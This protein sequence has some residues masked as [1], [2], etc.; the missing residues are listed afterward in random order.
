MCDKLEIIEMQLKMNEKFKVNLIKAIEENEYK[1]DIFNRKLLQ[2]LKQLANENY[3]L[4]EKLLSIE[5][6]LERLKS[7]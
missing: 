5:L 6:E 4:Y 3:R 7:G 2:A 1:Q